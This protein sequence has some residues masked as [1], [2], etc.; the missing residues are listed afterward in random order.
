MGRM[1]LILV[2]I[3]LFISCAKEPDSMTVFLNQSGTVSIKVVDN[4][5]NAFKGAQVSIYSSVPGDQRIYFDSTDVSGICNVGK[6]L[7]GQ[8]KYHVTAKKDKPVY[9]YSEYFQIIA[10]D[11]RILEVNPF[12]NT[13]KISIK[14][15]NSQMVPV[16]NV[17]IA[18]IPHPNF[19]NE[20]YIF[21][22]LIN[23]AHFTS[24][25]NTDGWT[26]F[27]GI[28]VD[29]EYSVLVYFDNKNYSYPKGNNYAF[30]NRY[31][32]RRFTIQA[33]L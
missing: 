23:E 10:G 28:P 32:E 20:D 18:L 5:K 8:Y 6:I 21:N 16:G 12:K 24:K 27:E 31:E 13:G 9:S 33:N 2:F 26:Q 3:A 15:I 11:D 19:S 7:Q 29:R 4:N 25:T 22:D 1:N 17:N 14:I 30:A